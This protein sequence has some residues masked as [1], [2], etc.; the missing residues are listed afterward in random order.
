[1]VSIYAISPHKAVDF[2]LAARDTVAKVV[3]T[4]AVVPL[5]V[6]MPPP[7]KERTVGRISADQPAVPRPSRLAESPPVGAFPAQPF[8]QAAG[9]ATSAPAIWVNAVAIAAYRAS[10]DLGSPPSRGGTT[11]LLEGDWRNPGAPT[12]AGSA[13]NLVA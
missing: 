6:G 4:A 11:P 1:M 7:R 5:G 8:D 12:R 10:A 9:I 2:R 3:P 13:V